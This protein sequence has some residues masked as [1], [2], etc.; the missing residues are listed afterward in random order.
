M[1]T[2]VRTGVRT[3]VHTGVRRHID[4]DRRHICC[5]LLFANFT[6]LVVQGSRPQLDRSL[7]T[8]A[9]RGTR[10]PHHCQEGRSENQA[11]TDWRHVYRCD[12]VDSM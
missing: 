11:I 4:I 12:F 5:V 9:Y 3:G 1:H 10:P 7:G 8:T 2:G 6:E